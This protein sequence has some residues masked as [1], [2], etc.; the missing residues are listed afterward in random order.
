MH[1]RCL[2]GDPGCEV[3]RPGVVVPRRCLELRRAAA[4]P[5]ERLG[6]ALNPY[7]RYVCGAEKRMFEHPRLRAVICNSKMVRE[8][9]RR[10]FRIAPEKLHVIYGGGELEPSPPRERERLRAAARAELGCR[11][12]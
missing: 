9:I 8:E 10:G 7:H 2:D 4:G 1:D 3:Y 12:R 11:P 6:I 5:L